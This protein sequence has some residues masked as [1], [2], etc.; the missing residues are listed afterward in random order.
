MATLYESNLIGSQN[1][2][3]F[4]SGWVGQSFKPVKAHLSTYVRLKAFRTNSPGTVTVSIRATT[5]AGLPTGADLASGTFDGNAVT[6]DTGGEVVTITWGTAVLLSTA[7]AYAII[8]RAPSGDSSNQIKFLLDNGGNPYAG[9][10]TL[11]SEDSGSSWSV[12]SADSDY[13]FEDFGTASPGYIWIEGDNFH[14]ID[15]SG[16]EQITIAQSLFDANTIL[17]ADSDD[18]PAALTVAEERLVGRITS[19]NIDDLTPAQVLKM[20]GAQHPLANTYVSGTGTAGSDNT[21]QDVKT[22]VIPANTLTQVNDRIRIRVYWKGD[23]GGAITATVKV[24]GVTIATSIDVGGATLFTNQAWLHYIDAST[25]NIIE[26][27]AHPATGANSAANVGGFDWTSNQNVVVS[28]DQ[29]VN[30]HI[31]VFAI[32][33]DVMPLGVV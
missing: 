27:G 13:V 21:A 32:F 23:T 33:L 14:W 31:V 15:S 18:T 17:A 1:G 25:A 30:N 6:T 26:S 2:N 10:E 12:D 11:L 19:G 24:N 28:Q 16:V 8:M 4:G 22:V 9:G 3:A 29:V 5:S 7:V 20:L